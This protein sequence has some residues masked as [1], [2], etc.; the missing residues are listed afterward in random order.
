[1]PSFNSGTIAK[2]IGEKDMETIQKSKKF[3]PRQILRKKKN[4]T[5][6]FKNELAEK[7]K[8]VKSLSTRSVFKSSE[9]GVLYD[10]KM[11]KG[12]EPIEGLYKLQRQ[13]KG[14]K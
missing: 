2:R 12:K 11:S 6:M 7:A 1:M 10:V 8:K 9:D 4:L 3:D 13:Y 14:R 5:I